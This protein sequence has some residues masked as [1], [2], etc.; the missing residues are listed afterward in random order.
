MDEEMEVNEW[1]EYGDVSLEKGCISMF[2]GL[3]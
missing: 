3:G 2:W 1:M